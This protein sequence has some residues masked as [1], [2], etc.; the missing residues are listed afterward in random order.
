MFSHKACNHATT[1]AARRVCRKAMKK[2]HSLAVLPTALENLV[3]EIQAEQ[4]KVSPKQRLAAVERLEAIAP[5][6][7]EGDIEA[8]VNLS[9]K[10]KTSIAKLPTASILKAVTA[11]L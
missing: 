1:P 11:A 2:D 10:Q 4:A 8:V 5:R 3:A 7:T 9:R 6:Y